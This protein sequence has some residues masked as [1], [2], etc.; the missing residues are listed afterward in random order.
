MIKLAQTI[1]TFHMEFA[2][3]W[4]I[5]KKCSAISD[6]WWRRPFQHSLN[7]SISIHFIR[8]EGDPQFYLDNR[9]TVQSVIPFYGIEFGKIITYQNK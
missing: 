2:F 7:A 3:L 8:N 4:T 9:K 1:L 6:Y 5:S